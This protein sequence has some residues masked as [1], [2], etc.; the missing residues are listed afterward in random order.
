[1]KRLYIVTMRTARLGRI[2]LMSYR[3]K[4]RGQ[5]YLKNTVKI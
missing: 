2:R 4:W 5:K 1:M 3:E